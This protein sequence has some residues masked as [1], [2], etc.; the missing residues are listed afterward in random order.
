MLFS[1]AI[2]DSST[3]GVFLNWALLLTSYGMKSTEKI[4]LSKPLVFFKNV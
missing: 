2:V 3:D 4:I 1:K